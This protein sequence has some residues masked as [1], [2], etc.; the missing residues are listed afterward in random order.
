MTEPAIA[1]ADND[2]AA[3][4]TTHPLLRRIA[5]RLEAGGVPFTLRLHDGQTLRFGEGAPAFRV[6]LRHPRALRALGT[7]DEGLI[8]EAYMEGWIDVDGEFMKMLDLR[9]QFD[10]R[11]PL[12]NLWRFIQPLV[13]GQV[14]T[15]ARAI[16][17]HYDLDPEFYLAFFGEGR[18]YTQGIFE[19]D[20]EPLALATRRKF[21]YAFDQLRL[22]PG[23]HVLEIGPG[24]GAF[25]EYAHGRGLRLSAVTNSRKSEEFMNALGQRLG[26]DWRIY[27]QDILRF[28]PGER[29][30]AIVMMGIIE[31]LPDYAA[32]LAKF[33]SLLKP[34]ARVF[35]DGSAAREKYELSSFIHRYIYQGNHSFWVLHDFLRAL[36]KTPFYLGDIHDDR[37]SYYLSFKHWAENFERNRA[38]VVARFGEHNFRRFQLYLWGS[39]HSFLV[40]VLQCYRLVLQAP[41]DA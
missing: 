13:F 14:G 19:R 38:A 2:V 20:D 33:Q 3:S 1:A 37:H 16:K 26:A 31:H 15:N 36:A 9:K 35:M 8:A 32:V 22:A 23:S 11:H 21:D 30:D 5:Q 6:S 7:L 12:T 29:Y 27:N 34:G 4:T 28:A 40:D 25:A 18:C 17:S 10:D 24:W 41:D 39:A